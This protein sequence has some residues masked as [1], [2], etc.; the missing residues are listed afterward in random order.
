MKK[1]TRHQIDVYKRQDQG[2]VLNRIRQQGKVYEERFEESGVRIHALVER[3][4]VKSLL[5]YCGEEET[6]KEFQP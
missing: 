1:I 4:I 3:K 2:S 5:P 6:E